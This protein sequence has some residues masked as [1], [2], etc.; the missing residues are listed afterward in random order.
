MEFGIRKSVGLLGAVFALAASS[1]AVAQ[2][3]GHEDIEVGVEGGQIVIENG[4]AIAGGG[5]LFESEFGELGNPFGT[6]E[7]GFELD[8]GLFNPGE[9]LAYQALGALQYWDGTAWTSTVPDDEHIVGEALLGV[10]TIWDTSGVFDSLGFIGDADDEG[11]VHSHIEFG[12][13]SGGAGDPANGAYIIELALL[14][15]A[16][17]QVTQIYGMSDSLFIAFNMGLSEADFEFAVDAFAAPVPVPGAIL[18]LLSGLTSLVG[19]RRR[20]NV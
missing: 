17:D 4:I 10:E 5:R 9:I 19:L 7:P 12:I 14:G 2:H 16:A 3:G 6:D 8:D 20:R 15:I 13:E 18:L 1:A 11:G